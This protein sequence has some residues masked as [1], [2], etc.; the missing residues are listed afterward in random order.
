MPSKKEEIRLENTED[1]YER[2]PVYSSRRRRADNKTDAHESTNYAKKIESFTDRMFDITELNQKI[3]D[4]VVRSNQSLREDLA[5]LIGKMENLTKK[6]DGFVDLMNQAMEIDSGSS[7]SKEVM[8]AISK[9]IVENM[10]ALVSSNQETSETIVQSMNDMSKMLRR[11]QLTHISPPASSG[12]SI[13]SRRR[14]L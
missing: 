2:V 11:M 1:D 7:A 8:D 5:V 9:P 14:E 6:M 3:I 12:S 13:L 10:K 4:D